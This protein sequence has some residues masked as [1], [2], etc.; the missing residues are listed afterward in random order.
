MKKISLALL[1]I[2]LFNFIFCN[3][4]YAAPDNNTATFNM[5]SMEKAN[6]DGTVEVEGQTM[7]IDATQSIVGAILGILISPVVLAAWTVSTL[8]G[9]VATECGYYHT[10]SDFGADKDNV[11]KV[12]SI[13][14]GEFLLFDAGIMKTTTNLN[15]SITP[16]AIGEVYNNVKESAIGMFEI[17]RGVAIFLFAILLLVTVIRLSV[18]TVAEERAKFKALIGDWIKGILFVFIVK[19]IIL[20]LSAVLDVMMDSLWTLRLSLETSNKTSFEFVVYDNVW[21]YLE[22]SGGMQYFAYGILYIMLVWVTLKFTVQ[23]LLR[24]FK[25]AFLVVI[26]PLVGALYTFRNAGSK[27]NNP[28]WGWVK[29]FAMQL[30]IQPIHAIIYLVFMFSAT[31]IAINAPFLGIMF[32]WALERAEKIIKAIF[33]IKD[34]A[35]IIGK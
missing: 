30:Y 31:E 7:K 12:S 18:S 2:I 27:G 17:L 9:V 13:I 22:N 26:S 8:I 19:Y 4:A 5:S 21:Q 35:Y 25:V 16:S 20:L 32:L 34:T 1:I 6:Q 23:Y 33:G 24:V 11:L 29:S 10:D 15:S 14:F 3:F 28:I